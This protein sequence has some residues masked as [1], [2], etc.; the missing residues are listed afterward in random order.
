MPCLSRLWPRPYPWTWTL[1]QASLHQ[2]CLGPLPCLQPTRQPQG[3]PGQ[4]VPEVRIGVLTRQEF[5]RTC[6]CFLGIG[7][8]SPLLILRFLVASFKKLWYCTLITDIRILTGRL[9]SLQGFGQSV[10]RKGGLFHYTLIIK[11]EESVWHFYLLS[12]FSS[13]PTRWL[14]S[15]SGSEVTRQSTWWEII[16]R[17]VNSYVICL[18]V[19]LFPSE[20]PLFIFSASGT[21]VGWHVGSK[22]VRWMWIKLHYLIWVKEYPI[23]LPYL[24]RIMFSGRR[25]RWQSTWQAILKSSEAWAPRHRFFKQPDVSIFQKCLTPLLTSRSQ[26]DQQLLKKFVWPWAQHS[27]SCSLFGDWQTRQAPQTTCYWTKFRASPKKRGFSEIYS[28]LSLAFL[29]CGFCSLLK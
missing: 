6:F 1:L 18:F 12:N 10:V 26:S 9:G 17:F 7:A 16:H 28:A 11:V 24:K 25:K 19:S 27:V 23:F 5:E 15:E 8:S 21:C 29:C 2:A 20:C 22:D 14:L 4:H 13:P 3:Q